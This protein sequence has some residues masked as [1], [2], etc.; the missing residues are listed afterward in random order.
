MSTFPKELREIE[1]ITFCT[2]VLTFLYL[3]RFAISMLSCASRDS[4][5]TGLCLLMLC[6]L[7]VFLLCFAS[8]VKR[9]DGLMPDKF[10]VRKHVNVVNV[11]RCKC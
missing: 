10:Q 5:F 4:G 8:G 11:K 9:C 3:G 1:V 7:S 6:V 2:F